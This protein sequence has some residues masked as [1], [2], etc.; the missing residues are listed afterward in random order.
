M[1]RSRKADTMRFVNAKE[2]ETIYD[3]GGKHRVTI[4]SREDGHMG[5]TLRRT[6]MIRMKSALCPR[7]RVRALS[8]PLKQPAGKP[9]VGLC[10]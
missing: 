3:A 9:R 7:F 2:I 8:N 5:C 4:F 6:A 1:T 10:S